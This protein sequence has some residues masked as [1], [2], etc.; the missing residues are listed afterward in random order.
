ME[1][2]RTTRHVRGDRRPDLGVSSTR[3]LDTYHTYSIPTPHPDLASA[4][5]AT[6]NVTADIPIDPS[7]V[8]DPTPLLPQPPA[9][10]NIP[11]LEDLVTKSGLPLEDVLN[12]H[13]AV[14][15]ALKMSDLKLIGLEHGVLNIS[16]WV[17]EALT[18]MHLSTGLPWWGSIAALTITIR[19]CLFPLIVRTLKHNVRL[20]AVQP[21]MTALFKRL[22]EAKTAQ[23][24]Q[25]QQV[26]AQTLT[27]LMKTHDVSPFR[28][29][30]MPLVQ[31]PFFLGMF[32]ALRKLATLPLPQL[33]EG[34]LGWVTDLTLADPYYIL[35]ITSMLFTNLV[36]RV[37]ADGTGAGQNANPNMGH[38][39]N[40]LGVATVLAIP[41]I[42][43]MPAAVLFYWTFTNLFTLLQ[44]L[45]L[46]QPAVKSLLKIP[47]PPPVAA[48]PEGESVNQN[49]SLLETWRA[50]REALSTRGEAWQKAKAQAEAR[51]AE[52]ERAKGMKKG[53]ALMVERIKEASVAEVSSAP[54][55]SA[56]QESTQGS[57]S[58]AASWMEGEEGQ[59]TK[60]GREMVKAR[61]IAAARDRRTRQQ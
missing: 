41:F 14:H 34:G 51:S 15:A 61:R 27:N 57:A 26:V 55:A 22:Q 24:P 29:L 8:T 17:Q 59:N 60:V 2:D 11:S 56:A 50:L 19:M 5:P 21:Q 28:P 52:L 1:A 6:H 4:Q 30:L 45:L 44:A 39:R 53:S 58:T 43:K 10:P 18:A 49:P 37:G 13:E 38:F 48:A 33:K 23:D 54:S 12:S 20:Q 46:R 42:G 32:Y 25:A 7:A 3:R 31:M 35:P 40:A 36:L 9:L 16:G 47:T